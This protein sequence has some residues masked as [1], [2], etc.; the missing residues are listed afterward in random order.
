MAV[1]PDGRARKLARSAPSRPAPAIRPVHHF[2]GAGRGG[3][4][5]VPPL[6]AAPAERNKER[7]KKINRPNP[8][9][10]AQHQHCCCAQPGQNYCKAR[11]R[12]AATRLAYLLQGSLGVRLV[13]L[14]S[15][16]ERLYRAWRGA[17]TTCRPCTPLWPPFRARS[18]VGAVCSRPVGVDRP[19]PPRGAMLGGA[20]QSARRPTTDVLRDGL[21]VPQRQRRS[22]AVVA[23]PLR[24]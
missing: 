20:G 1:R 21:L 16:S 5:S 4:R 6:V 9:R 14:G 2:P 23:L 19:A 22:S 13:F 11:P 8:A 3:S 10:P 7:L 24:R 12:G 17:V 18:P 15:D